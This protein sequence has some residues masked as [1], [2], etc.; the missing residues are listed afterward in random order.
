MTKISKNATVAHTGTGLVLNDIFKNNASSTATQKKALDNIFQNGIPS[1]RTE[2]WRYTTLRKVFQNNLNLV[3]QSTGELKTHP[4]LDILESVDIIRILNG[5]L[6]GSFQTKGVELTVTENS[7]SLDSHKHDDAFIDNLN[8]AFAKQSLQLHLDGNIADLIVLHFHHTIADTLHANRLEITAEKNSEA[9][10]L[11]LHTSDNDLNSTLIPVTTLLAHANSD[12][13]IIHLQDLGANTHQLGKTHFQLQRDAVATLTQVEI[14]GQLVRHDI[15]VDVLESGAEFN[16]SELIHGKQKQHH[17]TH[18]DVYH[19]APHTQSTMLIK[20]ALDDRSRGVFNGKIYV[21]R[22]AQQVNANLNNDNLLLS[23]YA[24]INTKPELEIYAD[25]VKCAH[26]ATVGQLDEES[27]FYL[28]T[29]G[30]SSDEAESVLTA[31]F[32]RSTYQS[33]VPL[34]LENWLDERLGF[35]S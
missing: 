32:S 24:E 8:I 2:R 21:E 34:E 26:G 29:R 3:E 4:A 30:L 13:E 35:K 9:K 1:L 14:G 10:I 23:Q 28:R 20:A 17:D 25:D 16:V 19:H 18:L 7:T 27:V 12:I 11:I 22:D 5:Q 6:H 15:V 33:L 31:A